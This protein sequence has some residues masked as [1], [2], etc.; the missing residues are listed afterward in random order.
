MIDVL[1][2][3]LRK[4][5]SDPIDT[6]FGWFTVNEIIDELQIRYRDMIEDIETREYE[7]GHDEGYDEGYDDG[8]DTAKA[9]YEGAE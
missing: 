7:N 9:Q 1:W 8:Y 6:P 3:S 5:E 2:E 4:V